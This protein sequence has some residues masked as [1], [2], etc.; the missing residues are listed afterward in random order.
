MEFLDLFSEVSERYAAIRPHYPDALFAR[1]AQ[2][3]PAR[4]SAWD[5]ATGNGQAAHGM[6]RWFE[7]VH[8]T[9]ASA[10]QIA[11]A[12]PHERIHYALAPADASGLPEA[13]VDLVTVAQALHWLDR[14]RFFA[15]AQ[16]VLRP[17]GIIAVFGYPWFY[18]SA[19]IDALVDELL[20]QPVVRY[21]LPNRQLLWD[22]YLTVEFPFEELTP[23]R[24][25][26]YVDWNLEQLLGYY[27]TSSGPRAAVQAIGKEFFLRAQ[28]RLAAA[29][30]DPRRA[31]QVVF[32]L[33][34]RLG[35]RR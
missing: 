35:R 9:D 11:H 10:A 13:S 7:H 18:V 26:I 4:R 28:Q 8:A 27:L 12:I 21:W 23:S 30:G 20:L 16:R 3:A 2:L 14:P 1:C 22:G 15:E 32:P 29:W 24:L 31:R 6:A 34:L 17:D 33:A 25:A 5:C 19:D